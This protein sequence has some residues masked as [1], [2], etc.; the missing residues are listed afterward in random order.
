M[1]LEKS[2]FTEETIKNI[3]RIIFT[4]VAMAKKIKGTLEL[5]KALKTQEK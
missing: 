5:P 4:V 1:S 3:S 2:V